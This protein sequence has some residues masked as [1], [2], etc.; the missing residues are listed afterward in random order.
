M[1]VAMGYLTSPQPVAAVVSF[2]SEKPIGDTDHHFG[3]E[4][5]Y[6]ESQIIPQN[7]CGTIRKVLL[8]MIWR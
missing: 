1:D 7:P 8:P 2:T 4:A 3:Y 5:A 6:P